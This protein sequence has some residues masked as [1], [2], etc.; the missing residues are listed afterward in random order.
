MIRIRTKEGGVEIEVESFND[1]EKVE[2]LL[3][4]TLRPEAYA[5]FKREVARA[6][7]IFF[8]FTGANNEELPRIRHYLVHLD[9][10][11][12][13]S[14]LSTGDFVIIFYVHR[15]HLSVAQEMA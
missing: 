6:E 9:S 2:R 11:P 12:R 4:R 10:R 13:G 15:D 3:R 7:E 8:E 1:P 5:R 14:T